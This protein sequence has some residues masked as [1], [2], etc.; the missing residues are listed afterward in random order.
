MPNFSYYHVE[1]AKSDNS[2]EVVVTGEITNNSD[3]SYSTVAVRI[4]LFK[5]N[6]TVANV[7]FTVNGL[8]A[9]ASKA[10]KKTIEDLEYEQVGK[11]INRYDIYTETAF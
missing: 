9:G 1:I 8:P 7:I 3:K 2:K 6:V 4:V 11:D 5:K 10:F